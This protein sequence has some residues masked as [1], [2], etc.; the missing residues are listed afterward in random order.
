MNMFTQPVSVFSPVF[1]QFFSQPITPAVRTQLEAQFSMYSDMTQRLFQSA[2]KIND[3]NIQVAQAVVEESLNGAHQVMAA[4]DTFEAVAIAAGQ[5]QPVAERVRSYQ[6]HLTNIAAGT[7]AELSR[8]A[9]QHIPETTRAASAVAEEVTRRVNEETERA[10]ER[11]RAA[12]E[13]LKNNPLRTQSY[14]NGHNQQGST[15]Q[16]R[17]TTTETTHTT[18]Q[19]GGQSGGRKPA[20]A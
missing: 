17:T 18:Q 8:A 4:K 9:E 7:Q 3:L 6:Q 16:D 14:Q 12:L 10:S 13:K 19:S 15:S 11:Q 2:Q 5:A 1:P 20:T